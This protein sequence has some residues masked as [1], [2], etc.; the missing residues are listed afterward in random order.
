MTR[1]YLSKQYLHIHKLRQFNVGKY[2]KNKLKE[3]PQPAKA[4]HSHDLL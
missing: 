2:D 4:H 1:D 3:N